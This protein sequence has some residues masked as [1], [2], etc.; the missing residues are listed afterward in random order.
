MKY[1]KTAS[2]KTQ[3]K[4]SK[5]EWKAIGKKAGWIQASDEA[6][7]SRTPGL[8]DN[9]TL[10]T[11]RRQIE[12][13]LTRDGGSNE[14]ARAMLDSIMAQI[15]S[16]WNEIKPKYVGQM[17]QL[18][19]KIL[20]AV[21]DRGM[22]VGSVGQN[23]KRVL[24]EAVRGAAAAPAP[25]KNTPIPLDTSKPMPEIKSSSDKEIK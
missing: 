24:D 12:L 3:L 5:S 19:T 16:R 23:V 14:T 17:D 7:D 10:K 1:I 2:G 6:I 13:E 9:S 20:D 21:K 15:L 4:I 18:A 11:L 22:Y 25:V 8:H